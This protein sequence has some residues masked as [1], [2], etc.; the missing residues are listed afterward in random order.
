[1]LWHAL[2]HA[3]RTGQA[4]SA[5]IEDFL[6]RCVFAFHALLLHWPGDGATILGCENL[7][8]VMCAANQAAR[9][10]LTH[11]VGCGALVSRLACMDGGVNALARALVCRVLSCCT[12]AQDA[13]EAGGRIMSVCVASKDAFDATEL[14][15]ARMIS[16]R[17][18]ASTV[19]WLSLCAAAELGDGREA[20]FDGKVKVLQALAGLVCQGDVLLSVSEHLVAFADAGSVWQAWDNTG[21]SAGK[22]AGSFVSLFTSDTGKAVAHFARANQVVLAGVLV[23]IHAVLARASE[24]GCSVSAKLHARAVELVSRSVREAARN[25]GACAGGAVLVPRWVAESAQKHCH[26]VGPLLQQVIKVSSV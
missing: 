14:H 21:L 12:T 4:S 13:I 5:G 19:C 9:S 7:F 18:V 24:G 16:G 17:G 25:A 1:M 8:G 20:M 6:S 23:R 15:G 22:I 10:C 26:L 11:R 2:Q 3:S